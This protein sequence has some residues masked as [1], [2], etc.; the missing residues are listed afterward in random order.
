[1]IPAFKRLAKS[2][3]VHLGEDALLRGATPQHKIHMARDVQ[4]VDRQG[5][6]YIAQ[7]V[8]KI[9]VEDQPVPGDTFDLLADDGVTATE[10]FVLETLIDTNGYTSRF[11][12]RKTS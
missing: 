3:L 12:A 1:M 7:Y 4:M 9:N 10:S 6:L 5:N 11:T 8:A 2:V